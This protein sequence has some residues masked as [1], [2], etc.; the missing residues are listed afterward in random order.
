MENSTKKQLSLNRMIILTILIGHTIVIFLLLILDWV[1]VSNYHS[2]RNEKVENILKESV[3]GIEWA[4]ND[5]DNR[6]YQ[7]WLY[8]KNFERLSYN[9]YKDGKYNEELYALSAD[10]DNLL[11]INENFHGYYIY[12]DGEE[13][14]RYKTN[15]VDITYGE[16][17]RLSHVLAAYCPG[18]NKNMN[19]TTNLNHWIAV[20][21]EDNPV[22]AVSYSKNRATLFAVYSIKNLNKKFQELGDNVRTIYYNGNCFMANEDLGKKLQV[23][24]ILKNQDSSYYG[25][26]NGFKLYSRK[27]HK[28]N[29]WVTVTIPVTLWDYFNAWML[30]LMLAEVIFIICLFRL[31]SF[32]RKEV[33]FPLRGLVDQ[34]NQIRNG[35]ENISLHKKYVVTELQ[36]VNDTL[37]RMITELRDQKMKTYENIIARQKSVMQYLRLQLNPHF[38]LNGLKTLNVLAENHETKKMQ[39][40]IFL[41]ASNIR[42]LM[43]TNRETIMLREELAFCDNYIQLRKQTTGL[44]IEYEVYCEDEMDIYNIP[45]LCIQ[46]FLENSCKY[47]KLNNPL[48]VLQIEVSVRLLE[49]DDREFLD[50]TIHDNGQGYPAAVL[51][52]IQNPIDLNPDKDEHNIGINNIRRRC[53]IL[54]GNRAELSFYNAEGAVSELLLPTKRGNEQ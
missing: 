11:T 9:S 24:K 31:V 26:R 41:I 12:F 45:V 22:L 5:I 51:E 10:L 49:V 50:L 7:V 44:Q 8:D 47:A 42:Y 53:Q 38:Y 28:T 6:M 14:C 25:I 43:S 34:M 40:L 1:L 2:E 32:V 27:I 19:E 33:I 39:E 21:T 4:M 29:F 46:P 20:L 15:I 36:N 13:Q 17:E 54:Y 35:K 30:L 16:V 52:Q 48:G 18:V 37:N 3:D 23:D